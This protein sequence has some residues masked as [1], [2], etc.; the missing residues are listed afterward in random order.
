MTRSFHFATVIY[1][2]MYL[3]KCLSFCFGK[4]LPKICYFLNFNNWVIQKKKLPKMNL[5]TYKWVIKKGKQN[6][7]IRILQIKVKTLKKK[8]CEWT[9][10]L[11]LILFQIFTKKTLSSKKWF[12]V[13]KD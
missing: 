6:K 7:I 9:Q 1:L 2:S 4:Y 13:T 3:N 10:W 11:F 8:E 12:N 5:Q